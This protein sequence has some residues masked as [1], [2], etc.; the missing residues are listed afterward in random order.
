MTNAVSSSSLSSFQTPL[1]K[2]LPVLNSISS[3]KKTDD[4]YMEKEKI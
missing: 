3:I 4:N 2:D 1:Q